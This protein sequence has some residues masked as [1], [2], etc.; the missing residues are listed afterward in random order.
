MASVLRPENWLL[1]A[2]PEME[3]VPVSEPVGREG[4]ADPE[5][6]VLVAEPVTVVPVFERVHELV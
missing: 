2:E 3:D 4:D 5:I 6:E 1:S